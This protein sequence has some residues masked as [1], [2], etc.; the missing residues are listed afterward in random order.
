[1]IYTILIQK[2]G[3]GKTTTT[4]A[5]A[6]G[7]ASKG[8]KVLAI[9]LDPLANL[10]Y[11]LAADATHAG[12]Y[13]LLHGGATSRSIQ[14]TAQG[15]DIISAGLALQ[16]EK[17]APGSARRLQKALQPVRGVYDHIFIDAPA[18]AGELQ[19]NGLQA[20]ERLIIPGNAAAYD[21]QAIYQTINTARRIQQSN[22]ALKIA[23]IIITE[24]DGRTNLAKKMREV[25]EQKGEELAAPVIGVIRKGV[26]ISE[27][28]ALQQS[29]FKY[30]PKS[31]PAQDYEAVIKKL[32]I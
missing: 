24:Y 17:S 4:A 25:I 9:D 19:Y 20:A 13:E 5:L 28:A 8:K 2:G 6:Q 30:A 3:A 32:V 10:T 15:I 18:T 1:M 12:A 16:T 21:L 23:G 29:L 22:E 11:A 7:A 31:K 27:A 26:A 14:R